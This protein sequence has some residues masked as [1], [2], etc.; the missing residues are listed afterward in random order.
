ML[1]ARSEL[2]VSLRTLR[3]PRRR[4]CDRQRGEC[5]QR[6]NRRWPCA[7]RVRAGRIGMS[8]MM[9]RMIMAAVVVNRA[10]HI[11]IAQHD[12]DA[13]IHRGQHETGGDERPQTQHRQ[14]EW[15]SPVAHT[16][17]S[18]PVGASAHGRIKMRQGSCEIK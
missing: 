17:V 10:R 14:D 2:C 11:R 18:Q 15:R 9:A 16:V 7:L 3:R 8:V 4:S 13:P 1:A 6:R 12:S 5:G